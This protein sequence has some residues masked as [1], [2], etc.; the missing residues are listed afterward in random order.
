MAVLL[1][2]V[3]GM[4][5]YLSFPGSAFLVSAISGISVST[6]RDASFFSSLVS[7]FQG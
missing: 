5:A 1:W 2:D 3:S 7:D 4:L 6:G